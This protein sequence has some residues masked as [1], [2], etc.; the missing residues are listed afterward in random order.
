LASVRDTQALK[1]LPENERHA[2]RALWRDVDE[3]LTRVTKKDEPTKGLKELE[4][5]KAQP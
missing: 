2:W 3:L 5:P 4:K 1:R